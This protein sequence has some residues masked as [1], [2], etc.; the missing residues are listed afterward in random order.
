MTEA[1]FPDP[2]QPPAIGDQ[3]LRFMPGAAQVIGFKPAVFGAWLR[4]QHHLRLGS[5]RQ[6]RRYVNGVY[7]PAED[8][9][10]QLIR[11]NHGE[12]FKPR[13]GEDVLKYL[14]A[15]IPQHEDPPEDR[16]N[17]ANGWLDWR[18][19]RLEPHSPEIYSTAQLPVA[20]NPNADCPMV[21]KFLA[22]AV[23]DDAID[24][25]WEMLGYIFYNRRPIQKAILLYGPGGNGKSVLLRIVEGLIGPH[26]YSTA[27]LQ[28]L[29]ENRFA[30]AELY[31]KT[32][33]VCGDL[34]ARAIT[35][36]DL[37][38]QIVGGDPITAE[39]KFKDPFSFKPRTVLVFSANDT[40]MTADQTDAWF[41]RWL[42]IPMPVVFR[43]TE[44]EDP[45]LPA[46]LLTELEGVLVKATAGLQRLIARGRFDDPPSV[47][48]AAMD[49]RTTLDTVAG[50]I[51]ER[52]QIDVMQRVDKSEFYRTYKEWCQDSGRYPVG[53]Q[54][55]N[56]RVTNL[57]DGAHETRSHGRRYWAGIGLGIDAGD[58]W[59]T[60]RP[61]IHAVY[62]RQNSTS[63]GISAVDNSTGVTGVTEF[64][65]SIAGVK[66][67]ERLE[68]LSPLSPGSTCTVCGESCH[69]NFNPHPGHGISTSSTFMV[70][71][72]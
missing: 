54:R 1:S 45:H 22:E 39:R 32:A 69:P 70:A 63:E 55:F 43:G 35:R 48:L 64:P 42:I 62:D 23:P 4:R 66:G 26:A 3:Y 51:E 21:D 61:G 11:D 47:F 36:S 67:E 17:V 29:A 50:F 37:F 28:S 24:L 15:E 19:G 20:W 27:S 71:S 16:V 56:I 18:R 59:V 33:N 12:H 9:V 8:W 30:G 52:C 41:D 10:L 49:Y 34:D 60:K 57:V 46:K 68:K 72:T 65:T 7:V 14:R 6:I 5:D 31:G 53:A 2:T 58:K 25:V 13:S 44:R 40:P 38:K